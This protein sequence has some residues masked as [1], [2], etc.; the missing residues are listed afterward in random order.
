[1]K[2]I[3][4][5]LA[6]LLFTPFADAQ[7]PSSQRYILSES[8]VWPEANATA[9]LF[10]NAII[11]DRVTKK[12]YRCETGFNVNTFVWLPNVQHRCSI[13]DG[14][15]WPNAFDNILDQPQW[16]IPTRKEMPTNFR[17]VSWWGYEQG[18]VNLTATFCYTYNTIPPQIFCKKLET[19]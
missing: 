6:T 10:V 4:A 19:K 5:L 9:N 18:A 11:I 1:M 3:L 14:S 15:A 2:H 16:A 8:Y 12:V 17:F 13:G 7:M